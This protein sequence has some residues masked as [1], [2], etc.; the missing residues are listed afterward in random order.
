MKRRFPCLSFGLR[1][2]L[3]TSMAVIVAVAILHNIARQLG[4]AEFDEV[5]QDL[6][7]DEDVQQNLLPLLDNV[8]GNIV[9]ARLIQQ[10]FT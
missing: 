3:E 5:Q 10:Y 7:E 1:V 2:K 4:E 9:R 6:Q 8:R